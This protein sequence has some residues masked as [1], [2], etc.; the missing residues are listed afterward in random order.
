LSASGLV[1]DLA[2]RHLPLNIL[3][4][5][6]AEVGAQQK[7]VLAVVVVLA[8]TE[9]LSAAK[10]LVAAHPLKASFQFLWAHTR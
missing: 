3:L 6:V 5:L 1:L 10:I 9:V 2:H 7:T 4:L 8:V